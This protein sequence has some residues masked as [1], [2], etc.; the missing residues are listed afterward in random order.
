M[1]ST[2]TATAISKINI[3]ET[4]VGDYVSTNDATAGFG[5]QLGESLT[6][7][8][9]SSVPVTK[10]AEFQKA[11]STGTGTIDLTNLPGKT[12]D[13]TI[14][15]SGL[16]VQLVKFRNLATNANDITITFGASNPYNLLGS[17]FTLTLKPGQS[18]LMS[19]DEAA[20]DISGGAKELDISGTGSQKLE[21]MFVMG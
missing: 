4:F 8:A 21:C 3:T 12:L 17:D 18:I 9:G 14:D 6:L 20:P 7:T 11:L 10:H 16:K 15:G 1:S 19:L 2:I 13:E 5:D